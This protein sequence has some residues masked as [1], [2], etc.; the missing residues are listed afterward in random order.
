MDYR[1]PEID[2]W[3]TAQPHAMWA[4]ARGHCPVVSVEPQPWEDTGSFH[5]LGHVDAAAVL[6]DWRTFSSTINGD[7]MGPFMGDLI[8]ALDGEEHRQYRNLVAPAFRRSNLERWRT[9]LIEPIVGRLLDAV[10]PAGR[11]DLVADFTVHY[12]VQVICGIV[13]VPLEDHEQFT[14]WA[15]QINHG[16]LDPE[17]GLAASAAM[18]EY[19]A[20]LVEA[21]RSEPTG[22]LLSELANAEV[23]GERLSEERLYG[24]L[25][26][27][28]PAGAETTYRALG[29]AIVALLTLPHVR[30]RVEADRS[31]IPRL[32]EETLRW[33]TSITM[34]MRRTTV[35]TELGGCPIPAGSPITVLNGSAGRGPDRWPD[36]DAFDIDREAGA[37]MGFGG[38]PHLCLGMHLA[39]LEMEVGV[40]AVL[41]L[42]PGVRLDGDAPVP[43]VS[44]YAFRGPT[45]LPVV[46]DPTPAEG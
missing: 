23:D 37:H 35:D 41:D 18:A 12:P 30:D 39:R 38:G 9:E 26:L 44:G 32:V 11:A 4:E 21:R 1:L 10:R 7:F 6:R 28:L 34:I 22:D 2:E 27:L 15:E 43:E 24:F 13:G 42:L 45:T 14:T 33:E 16:P 5:V 40:A 36:P 3:E 19:L 31:L 17:A 20:P 8:L 29:N 25:R 46:F